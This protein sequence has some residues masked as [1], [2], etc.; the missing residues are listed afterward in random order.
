MPVHQFINTVDEACDFILTWFEIDHDFPGAD[1]PSADSLPEAVR[2]LNSRLGQLWHDDNHPLKAD[3]AIPNSPVSLF[4]YQDAL[5][6]P[7]T[8]EQDEEGFFPV[9]T[10][11]QGVWQFGFHPSDLSELYVSRDWCDG[12]ESDF[13]EKWRQVGA[14]IDDAI[15]SVLLGNFCIMIS[16]EEDWHDAPVQAD[17]KPAAA[18]HLLWSHPAWR[19]FDG[20]WTN[21]ERNLIYYSQLGLALRRR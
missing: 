1:L 16:H 9:A 7:L 12:L 14:K 13:H 2:A 8:Y 21:S 3:L 15:I 19:G 5:L 18:D 6:D 10:E 20:F 4:D 11:N 17:A